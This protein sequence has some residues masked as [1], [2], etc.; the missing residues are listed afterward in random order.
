MLFNIASVVSAVTILGS[1]VSAAPDKPGQIVQITS[2]SNWCMMM[3]PMEGGDI[4]GSEDNAVAFCT[5]DNPD[6][7]GARVFPSGFIQSAHFVA[8]SGY[9]QVTG[10]IDRTRYS[11]SETDQ[12]GQYDIRAPVGS[13][14]AGY[15]YYVNLI[16]PHS[17]TYCI[18]CC[19]DMSDCNTGESTYGCARIIPGDYSGRSNDDI[20][21]SAVTSTTSSATSSSVTPTSASSSTSSISS[22]SS[23]TVH[24][25]TTLATTTTGPVATPTHS[26]NAAVA[27]NQPAGLLGFAAVAVAAILSL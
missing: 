7:P 20:A 17:N 19:T 24:A 16:E 21:D 14:C 12:G 15:N 13:S 1:V 6:A 3:P 22:A 26:P 18:R 10:Q 2:A 25:S 23:T 5:T 11:L 8:G 4:A 27:L 9:V